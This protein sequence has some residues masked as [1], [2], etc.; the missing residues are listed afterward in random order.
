MLCNFKGKDFV[1]MKSF[2][3]MLFTDLKGYSGKQLT[4]DIIAGIIVAIIALPLSIA[5]AIA[6][7]VGP[8][9]GIYTAVIAGFVTALFGGSSVQISGPTAA[10]A[11]IVA[12]IVARYGVEGMALATVIAGVILI[13]M[14]FF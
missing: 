1:H 3:P 14:G 9:M 7:G 6:S 13:V 12:G 2:N 4:S 11:T 8:E 5:L 10:F